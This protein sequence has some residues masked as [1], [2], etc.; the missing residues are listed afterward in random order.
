MRRILMKKTV[1]SALAMSSALA[2]FGGIVVC[3]D[4]GVTGLAAPVLKAASH[5][6]DEVCFKNLSLIKEPK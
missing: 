3:S 5:P 1:P 2:A 4:K 6:A